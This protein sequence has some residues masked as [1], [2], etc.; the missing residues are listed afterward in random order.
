MLA[1]TS[2]LRIQQSYHSAPKFFCAKSNQ[3]AV[4]KLLTEIPLRLRADMKTKYS[5][6]RLCDNYRSSHNGE[7]ECQ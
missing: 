6:H 3:L 7:H 5:S 4:V 2:I 1:Y